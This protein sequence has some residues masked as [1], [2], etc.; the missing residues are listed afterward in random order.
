MKDVV[1]M[2]MP[3]D[4]TVALGFRSSP[5]SRIMISYHHHSRHTETQLG[6]AKLRRERQSLRHSLDGLT[7]EDVQELEKRM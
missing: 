2:R 3:I 1:C 5:H 7:H 4:A 6:T